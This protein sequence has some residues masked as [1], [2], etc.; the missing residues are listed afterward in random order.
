MRGIEA[1]PLQVKVKKVGI[2]HSPIQAFGGLSK[3]S[4]AGVV[5]GCA[6]HADVHGLKRL[7]ASRDT[8]I[9][10]RQDETQCAQL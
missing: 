6:W 10:E 2:V 1:Q 8:A 3:L 7:C 9:R 5:C 4:G